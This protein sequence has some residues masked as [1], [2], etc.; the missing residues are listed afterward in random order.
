MLIVAPK[1]GENEAKRV[2]NPIFYSLKALRN[3][4]LGEI[5]P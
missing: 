4:A 2:E 5:L 1:Y 3:K